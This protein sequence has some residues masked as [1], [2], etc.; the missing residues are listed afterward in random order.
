MAPNLTGIG[1][2]DQEAS[3]HLVNVAID[4]ALESLKPRGTFLAK[5]FRGEHSKSTAEA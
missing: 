4:F 3:L 5:I 2:V 1:A